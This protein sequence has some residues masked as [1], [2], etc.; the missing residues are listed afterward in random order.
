MCPLVQGSCALDPV[1]SYHIAVGTDAILL[2][3]LKLTPARYFRVVAAIRFKRGWAMLLFILSAGVFFLFNQDGSAFTFF[4]AGFGLGYPFVLLIWLFVWCRL[5]RNRLIYEERTAEL[6]TEGVK[7]VAANGARSE[8]PW[9]Y[10]QKMEELAGY[11]L[12]HIGAGRLIL[13]ERVG[14]PNEESIATFKGWLAARKPL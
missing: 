9:S 8:V 12:L 13:L 4:M 1:R 14:F 7:V 11:F 5:P 3:P 2:K 10:V 6:N